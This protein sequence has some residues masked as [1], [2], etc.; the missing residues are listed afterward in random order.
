[1]EETDYVHITFVK[2]SEMATYQKN[3][4]NHVFAI[5]P[6]E[7]DE[8]SFGAVKQVMKVGSSVLFFLDFVCCFS[9]EIICENENDP[10]W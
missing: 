8:A 7:F 6:Q 3:W 5:L 4:P 2:Q 9:I 1:M 10:Q